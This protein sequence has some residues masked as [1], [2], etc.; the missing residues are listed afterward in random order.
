MGVSAFAICMNGK[1][2]KLHFQN[3]QLEC[4][5]SYDVKSQE[6]IHNFVTEKIT[7]RLKGIVLDLFLNW[8]HLSLSAGCPI[9]TICHVADM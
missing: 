7:T 8:T 6:F 9:S 3:V 5:A 2:I 1:T 4:K